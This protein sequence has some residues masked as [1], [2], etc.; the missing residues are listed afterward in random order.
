MGDRGTEAN[1]LGGEPSSP[2]H[3]VS[4]ALQKRDR[5]ALR[6]ANESTYPSSAT[7]TATASDGLRMELSPHDPLIT[8]EAARALLRLIQR[9]A[10]RNA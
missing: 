9:A 7:F 3:L 5:D 4:G 6:T 8:V 2:N 10:G 1:L